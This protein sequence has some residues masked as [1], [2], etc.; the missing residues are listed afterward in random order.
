MNQP[1][2]K[3]L[4][5]VCVSYQR[6]QQIPILIHSFLAQTLQN[7]K[8]KIYHDAPDAKMEAILARYKA[9]YPSLIDYQFTGQRYN[10]YGHSLRDIGIAEADGDYLLITNDDNYYVPRF[11][12]FMFQ[13]IEAGDVDL[14][15]CDMIHSHN[16]PGGRPQGPYM[17]FQTAPQRLAIDVGCMIVRTSIAKKFGWRDKGHDGD[18]TYLEDLIRA[19]PGLKYSKLSHVLF[20]HN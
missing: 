10:D 18:A 12:E 6:Y 8:L 7:F 2:R 3:T 11:L 19:A 4:S 9:E 17:L 15:L 1:P 13:A 14:V 20:V 5:I 16:R